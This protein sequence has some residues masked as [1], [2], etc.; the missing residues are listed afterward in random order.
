[1][2]I[3]TQTLKYVWE[4]DV[5]LSDW[6]GPC[7]G[8]PVHPQMLKGS[9]HESSFFEALESPHVAPHHAIDGCHLEEKMT[10]FELVMIDFLKGEIWC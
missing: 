8:V 10:K 5:D 3:F 9:L 2:A 4:N 1:M 6:G 7:Y